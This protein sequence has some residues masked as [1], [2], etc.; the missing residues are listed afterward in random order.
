MKTD[1]IQ[2]N[3]PNANNLRMITITYN[4]VT[5]LTEKKLLR[6]NIRDGL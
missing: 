5:Q 6:V 1:N 4:D 2:N 3:Y